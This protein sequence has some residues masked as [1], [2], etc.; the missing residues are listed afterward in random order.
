MKDIIRRLKRL[1]TA[2]LSDAMGKQNAMDSSIRPVVAGVQMIGRA[3]TLRPV[4]G[5]FMTVIAALD[6]VKAGN[7][8][9]IDG[10]GFTEAAIVGELV[11]MEAKRQGAVGIV[12]DGASRDTAGIRKLG[13]HL[14][15]KAITPRAGSCEAMGDI[16]IPISCGGVIVRPGDWVIGDDDGVT[17]IPA[18]RIKQVLASTEA[19]EEKEEKI[20]AG[21]R[22]KAVFGLEEL[23]AQR[24]KI[25]E[26]IRKGK[27][28][29]IT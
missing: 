8:M 22:I 4:P 7:V 2:S 16:Q 20:K 10:A 19:V 12:L 17:V 5:D 27:R 23:F 26:E 25:A 11:C 13:F 29:P 3:L 9:V 1:D 15:S 6:K 28:L 24:A 14:F 18:E 21:E